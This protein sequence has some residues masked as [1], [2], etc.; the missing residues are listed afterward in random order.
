MEL[1]KDLGKVERKWK[2]PVEIRGDGTFEGFR[3]SREKME[4][5]YENYE[6]MELSKDPG[7]VERN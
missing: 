6:G 2:F 7:K 4:L 5:Y 1:S 3:K